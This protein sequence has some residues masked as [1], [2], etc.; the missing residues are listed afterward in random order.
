MGSGT[1]CAFAQ[2]PVRF[3]E[4]WGK[5]VYLALVSGCA[6]SCAYC[7]RFTGSV[8]AGMAS[9]HIPGADRVV[10][11]GAVPRGK[12]S[13]VLGMEEE[14]QEDLILCLPKPVGYRVEET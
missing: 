6:P 14:R 5:E 11:A 1:G 2:H 13:S 12:T 9:H 8:D 10:L 7:C 4:G 3:L